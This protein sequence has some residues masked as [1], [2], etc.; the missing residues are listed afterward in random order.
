[1]KKMLLCASTVL[2]MLAC[3]NNEKEYDAT[4]TF[5]A[6]EVTI[7]AEQSGVLLKFDVNEGD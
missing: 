7:A 1:M 3:G 4:G 5:E 2:T 6:T